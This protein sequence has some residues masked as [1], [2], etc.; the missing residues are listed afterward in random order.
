MPHIVLEK[1][2]SVRECY[3]AIDV[4]VEK[5]DG[6]ILKITD[7]YINEKETSALLESV[8]V[9]KGKSQSFFIQLSSKGDAVTVR[10][11]PLTDPEKTNGVKKLMGIVAKKI[12]DVKPEISYGKTNLQDFIVE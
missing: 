1:A 3:D 9:D 4:M 11:L 8:T 10:L 2:K 5:I 6:G 7:K 12:K